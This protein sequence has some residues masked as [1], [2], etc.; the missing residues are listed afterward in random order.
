MTSTILIT[1]WFRVYQEKQ[2]MLRKEQYFLMMHRDN[3][4]VSNNYLFYDIAVGLDI[5]YCSK[6]YGHSTSIQQ[7]I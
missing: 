5:C 4:S 3:V 2:E 6:Y 7:H 1:T